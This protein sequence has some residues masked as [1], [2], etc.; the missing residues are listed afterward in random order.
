MEYKIQQSTYRGGKKIY[1]AMM[2]G[3]DTNHNWEPVPHVGSTWTGGWCVLTYDAINYT[4]LS[5]AEIHL[6]RYGLYL[7]AT[8]ITKVKNIPYKYT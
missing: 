7:D 2:K 4:R 1:V 5:Y 3:S 8:V 6:T